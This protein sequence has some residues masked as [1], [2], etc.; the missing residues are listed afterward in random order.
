MKKN[1]ID[2]ET[3]LQIKKYIHYFSE[4]EEKE[5]SQKEQEIY[6]KLTTHLKEK[7]LIQTYGKI[8]FSCPVF[9]NNFSKDFLLKILTIM[10]P[11]HFDSDSIIYKVFFNIKVIFNE[12]FNFKQGEEADL[13]IYLLQKGQVSLS[14]SKNSKHD[15]LLKEFNLKNIKVNKDNKNFK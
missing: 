2:F 5:A 9:S 15:N 3:Q 7:I 12:L 11:V 4:V 14:V 6:N 13:A 8:L 1:K 10:K